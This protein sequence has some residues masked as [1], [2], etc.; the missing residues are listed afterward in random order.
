MNFKSAFAFG[1]LKSFETKKKKHVFTITTNKILRIICI[2][3]S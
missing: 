2:Y 1:H 3:N